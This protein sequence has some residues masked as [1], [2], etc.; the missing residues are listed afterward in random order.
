MTGVISTG[1]NPKLLWP[2]IQA[3]WGRTYTEHPREYVE[4]F[5]VGTSDK[6]YEEDVEVTGFGLVPQKGEGASTQYDSETQGTVTRYTNITYSMGY[7]VTREEIADNLYFEA[8]KRRTQA[9]G[10]SLRQTEENVGANI[11]N[12][13]FNSSFVGGDGVEMIANDHPT[14]DGTQSNILATPSDLSEQALEDILIQIMQARNSRGL[15]ISLMGECLAVPPELWFD[16]NRIINSTLQT[17]TGNND[18]NVINATNALP[19]GI[20]V[21]HYFTDSDAWFVRTN[22]PN[23]L[24]WLDREVADFSEDNDFDTE[25]MK[26]KVFRRFSAGWSDWR[27]V[28]G[29]QGAA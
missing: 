11:F 19:K 25:N 26:A 13:A 9:L 16:A 5:D 12:R 21:N 10:F 4:L 7:I 15:K 6:S 14:K 17:G 2:G 29:S 22:C 24:K 18:I 1:S 23:S 28:Y 8:A 20:K 27:G 3:V